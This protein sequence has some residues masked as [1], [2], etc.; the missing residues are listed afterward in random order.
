M[1]L[2]DRIR[3]VERPD[4]TKGLAMQAPRSSPFGSARIAAL[5][6]IAVTA[7]GLAY[8]HLSGRSDSLVVPSG[9]PA[10][11]PER[12]ACHY[13]TE[14]GSYRADCGTLVVPEN[15]ADPR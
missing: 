6:L 3:S 15:R 13:D 12:H 5:A 2:G 14:R 8:L 7:L 4:S 11:Q 9:A 1:T 10:G